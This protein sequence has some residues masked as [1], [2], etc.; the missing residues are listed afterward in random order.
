MS[1]V[2]IGAAVIGAAT[3]VYAADKQADA[4]KKQ[5]AAQRESTAAQQK[6]S[7]ANSARERLKAIRE[8]RMRAGSI[9][10]GAAAGGVGQASSGVAGSIASIGS[11][12]G[13]NI[14][15]INVQEGFAEMASVANQKAADAGAEMAKW[16]G[17]G[18][19][20]QTIFSTA[21]SRIK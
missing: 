7:S 15:A 6:M 18:A 11:Q 5:A 8:A 2:V 16:Q 13:A 10:G 21:A 14:G 4:A 1:G 19:I 9:A 20:G 3:T 12:A 17:I